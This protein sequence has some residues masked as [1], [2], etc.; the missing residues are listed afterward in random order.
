VQRIEKNA[1]EESI[2]KLIEYCEKK[3]PPWLKMA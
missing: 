1:E 3:K 2:E